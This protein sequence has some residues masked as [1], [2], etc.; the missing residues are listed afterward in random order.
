LKLMEYQAK[1]VFKRFGIPVPRG[2]LARTAG[3]AQEVARELGGP[4][5]V[6]AQV[7]VGGRGKAGGI[8]FAGDPLEAGR[9]AG[10]LLGSELKGFRVGSVYVEERLEV[11]RELYVG[12]TLD[13]SAGRFVVLA[14]RSGGMDIEEV[15]ARTPEAIARH[16][17]DPLEG[18]RGYHAAY[19]ASRLGFQGEAN[20][21]LSSIILGLQ[22][23][24]QSTDAE[25]TEINPLVETPG[26]LVAADA[27]LNL[28]DNALFRRRE[29]LEEGW[30]AADQGLTPLERR[31]RERGLNYVELD[32]D[33]GV[34]GNGAGLTMATLDTVALYGGRPA[35]FLDLGGG[36]QASRVAEAASFLLADERVKVVL[37]N[38]LG[39]ITRCDEVAQGLV[40]ALRS[41]PKPKPMVVRLM[42][43]REEEGKAVLEAAGVGVQPSMEEA[44]KLAVEL[45]GGAR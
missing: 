9:V 41:A 14:S 26:G 13:R 39:G 20:R 36:A 40:E 42:G 2:G 30:G 38:I 29:L 16:H 11:Q 6:K 1:Q 10:E 5:V 7:P 31:A 24:A 27:R 12:V 44:A 33:I 34:I 15:A 3:E 22:M 18:F 19:L 45:G 17:V 23:L 21:R 4:V 32:G 35:N 28:D 43:T 37:V 8:K 25:L